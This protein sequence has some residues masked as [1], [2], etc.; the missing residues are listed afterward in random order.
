M[1]TTTAIELALRC[2]PA[3]WQ[4]RYAD[5]VRLVSQDLAA[6]GRSTARVSLNLLA[7][8]IRARSR[9]QGMP[10]SYGLWSART[11]VS[12]ATATLPWLL[13]APFMMSTVGNPKFHSSEGP[14]FSF[15]GFSFW[16]SHLQ[17]INRAQPTPSP[18]LAPAGHVILYSTL[19]IT[20]LFFVT[21]AV[22]ISGWSGL[23]R[24]IRQSETPNRR[25]LRLLAWTPVFALLA[26][27]VLIVGQGV[28]EPHQWAYQEHR[29][30]ASGGHPA[31]FHILNSA[32]PTVAIVG[33]LVSVACVAIAARRADIAPLELRF[34]K[35]VAVVV[36]TLFALLVAAY[37][38]WGIALIVQSQQTDTG[39]FTAVG[40]A[41]AGLWLPM[42]L[43]LA[44]A[45]ALSVASARAARSSWKL[46]SVTFLQ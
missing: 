22:L 29:E 46:I 40:Y 24:A 33:W 37:A 39:N 42:M 43:V 45:V 36:A 17:L 11:R 27:I 28:S 1:N 15:S 14:V 31:A 35:S 44:I 30:V 10:K 41:H 38:T 19:A 16:P 2:Y 25:S 4:E 6:E 32:L 12:I 26:D 23:T 9:A 34:G 8:A 13:V 18:P 21:F 7:G 20:A 3:W 5:E